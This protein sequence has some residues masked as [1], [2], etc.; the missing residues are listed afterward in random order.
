MPG[1]RGRP[2]VIAHRGASRDVAEH[3][4][5]AFRLAIEEGAE[6]LECDVRL[7]ADREL[8]CVHDLTVARTSNGSGP[9]STATLAELRALDWGEWRYSRARYADPALRTIGDDPA[10]RMIATLRDVVDFALEATASRPRGDEV[11]VAIETK[12]PTRYAGQ[13]ETAVA[14][15]VSAYGLAGQSGLGVPWVRVMSFSVLAVRRWAMLRPDIP[16]VYLTESFLPSPAHYGALPGSAEIAGIDIDLVRR[17]PEVVR[18]HQDNGH[19]VY[20][21][22]VDEPGDLDLCVELGVDA[23]ITNRP[24]FALDHVGPHR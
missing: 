3:T 12:H 10:N 23:V 18:R 11:G 5:G 21:W 6:A 24:R 9:V 15:L 17:K 20:V 22:T 2:L 1:A 4:I 8:V 7:T 19:G 13:V 16:G 14:D